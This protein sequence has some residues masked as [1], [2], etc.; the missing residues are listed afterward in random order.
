MKELSKALGMKQ[1]LSMVYHPQTNG[2][3]ERMNQEIEVFLLHYVNY[4]QDDWIAQMVAAEFQYNN[5]NMQL[6]KELLSNLTLDD[7][8]GKKTS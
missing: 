6:Q 3:I 7:I 8:H 1:T 4:Q 2:Q 5:K